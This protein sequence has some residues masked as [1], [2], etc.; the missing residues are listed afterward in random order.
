MSNATY[1]AA[2]A[3]ALQRNPNLAANIVPGLAGKNDPATQSIASA[4]YLRQGA[5]ALQS[6][7]YTPNPSVL[8]VR[9]FYN[10]GPGPASAVAQASGDALL[11][12]IVPLTAD[13]YRLNGI[14]PGVTTVG[15][16]RT[17]ITNKIGQTAA[18]TPVLL[19]S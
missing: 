8:D 13:Q 5:V 18:Q 10:F 11:S 7:G 3:A 1:N 12:N 2:L 6:T 14:S 15:Q 9:G 4:E 19:P 16:W 17:S